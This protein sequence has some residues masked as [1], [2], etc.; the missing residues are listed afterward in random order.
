MHRRTLI[1]LEELKKA[2]MFSRVGVLDAPAAIVLPSW[3]EAIA[4]SNSLDW[5]NLRLDMANEY[6]SQLRERSKE[7]FNKWNDAVDDVKKTLIPLIRIKIE[8]VVRE[9]KLPKEF[10]GAVQWDMLHVCM[11][12][13]YADVCPPGAY[14][15]LA[16]WY[17]K[18][19]FPCGW[20]GVFPQGIQII[21]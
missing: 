4:C 3:R 2:Q 6:R 7:K 5:R 18:G 14:E 19:H 8:P 11:E 9:H 21:Y 15:Y 16:S 17:L 10:E 13:E 1:F 20:Q 12:T